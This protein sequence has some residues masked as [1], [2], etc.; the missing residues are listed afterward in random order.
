MPF[1]ASIDSRKI[2]G[3]S[4]VSTDSTI[5]VTAASGKLSFTLTS[6]G[7]ATEIR[8]LPDTGFAGFN[9]PLGVTL[10]L[11]ASL[12]NGKAMFGDGVAVAKAKLGGENLSA[13][14]LYTDKILLAD[15]AAYTLQASQAAIAQIG[16]S[17]VA[18]DLRSTNVNSKTTVVAATAA[19]VSLIQLDKN[20]TLVLGAGQSY[21]LTADQAMVGKVGAGAVGD[22]LTSGALLIKAAKDADLS[23]LK[24]KPNDVLELGAGEDYVLN[25]A[26]TAV[27]KVGASGALGMF[28]GAGAVTVKANAATGEDLSLIKATGIDVYELAAG[29]AYTLTADQL[30]VARV[31][32]TG[33]TG[34]TKGAGVVTV[35]V[36]TVN[37]ITKLVTKATDVLL[38]NT[39]ADYRLTSEQVKIAKVGALTNKSGELGN[40]GQ[41]TV[42]AG[43]NNPVNALFRGEDLSGLIAR[44]VDFYELSAGSDYG[45]TTA[46]AKV[47]KVGTGALGN[48][49]AAGHVTLIAE[50]TGENLSLSPIAGVDEY[51][52]TALQTYTMTAEQALKARVLP[53]ANNVLGNF[54]DLANTKTTVLAGSVSDLTPI[55]IDA[56]DV[57]WLTANQDY[58]LSALQASVSRVDDG[59]AGPSSNPPGSLAKAGRVVIKANPKGE[60]LATLL[61]KVTGYDVIELTAGAKYSLTSAQAE[62][63]MVIAPPGNTGANN[64]S[65]VSGILGAA[66]N[67]PNV[68]FAVTTTS[69][70]TVTAGI[71]GSVY[72]Q[73]AYRG[74]VPEVYKATFVEQLN[75]NFNSWTGWENGRDITPFVTLIG[76]NQSSVVTVATGAGLSGAAIQIQVAGM[77]TPWSG[78]SLGLNSATDP[79]RGNLSSAGS[80]LLVAND[81]GEDLSG[82]TVQGIKGIQLTVGKDYTLTATQALM[83]S[84]SAAGNSVSSIVG[85]GPVGD[86]TYTPTPLAV[87]AKTGVMTIWANENNVDLTKLKTDA[88]DVLVLTAGHNYKLNVAQ[89]LTA[90]MGPGGTVGQLGGSGNITVVV[91]ASSTD[92]FKLNLDQGDLI[93]L[94]GGLN[95][96]LATHQLPL[97][98]MGGNNSLTKA[99][100]VTVVAS[101][102][103]EDLTGF[104]TPGIDAYVLNPAVNYSLR[105]DQAK[106]SRVG[107]SPVLGD[108]SSMTGEVNLRVPAAVSLPLDLTTI[109]LKDSDS[110]QLMSG[111]R[112]IL[113]AKQAAMA[114][115]VT[116]ADVGP[117]GDLSGAAQ[118]TVRP[119]AGNDLTSLLAG[120]QGIDRIDLDPEASYTLNDAQARMAGFG[121]SGML[122]ELASKSANSKLTLVAGDSVYWVDIQIDANDKIILQPNRAYTLTAEQAVVSQMGSQGIAGILANPLDDLSIITVLAPNSADLSKLVLDGNDYL[123]LGSGQRYTLTSALAKQSYLPSWSNVVMGDLSA[124]GAVRILAAPTGEDLSSLLIDAND[125]LVLT[126]GANY[127][128]TAAQAAIGVM[129][130]TG[131]KGK[132]AGTGVLT[133]K[134]GATSDLTSLGL[135]TQGLPTAVDVIQLD[136]NQNYSLTP[137]QA[138]VARVGSMGALGQLQEAGVL[139]IIASASGEDLSLLKW[140]GLD[141]NDR[142]VLTKAKNYTLTKDQLALAVVGAGTTG[143][144]TSAGVITLKSGSGLNE[145]LSTVSSVLGV[146]SVVLRNGVNT[147]LTDE[148]AMVAKLGTG[149]VRDLRGPVTP[150][151]VNEIMTLKSNDRDADLAPITTDNND[152]IWLSRNFNYSLNSAQVSRVT[153][154]GQTMASFAA[155]T[156]QITLK[157]SSIGEDLSG[158]NAAMVDV[159]Q[160]TAG[161]SYTLTPEQAQIATLGSGLAVQNT[162]VSYSG[163]ASLSGLPS[164]TH[165]YTTQI[166]LDTT[167][168]I[169]GGT[170]TMQVVLGNGTSAAS[171]DLYKNEIT[172][173]GAENRP[174]N[175]LKNAYYVAPGTTT[176]LS[177]TFPSS[178]TDTYVFGVEGNW[179]SPTSATNT[180]TYSINITGDAYAADFRNAG[181]ITIKA[182]PDGDNQLKTKLSFM[183]GLGVIALADAKDYTLSAGQALIARMGSATTPAVLTSTG[184]IT[185]DDADSALGSSVNLTRLV[186]DNADVLMLGRG[187]YDL[188]SSQVRKA[189]STIATAGTV[190]LWASST[191]ED[192]SNISA[193]T[194]DNVYLTA[195]RDYTLSLDQV[196][197]S[198]V[199]VFG[200][201][202][203]LTKAGKVTLKLSDGQSTAALTSNQAIKGVDVIQLIA[204]D[205]GNDGIRFTLSSG[206]S[207]QLQMSID[208]TAAPMSFFKNTSSNSTGGGNTGSDGVVNA[209]GEWSFVN[210]TDVLTYYSLMSAQSVTLIGVASVTADGSAGLKI[211]F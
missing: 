176:N 40:A 143:D 137:A 61:S 50:K 102:A 128:L 115:V 12:A 72:V 8:E 206:S 136:V 154:D 113:T 199:G 98:R 29:K 209:P 24:I 175:S 83:A 178:S 131:A 105:V 207:K 17:G 198:K 150:G 39:N 106:I 97:V 146:D 37:D 13:Y 75:P 14:V 104:D 57:F 118:I 11:D 2:I 20:D 81:A 197:K 45:L 15:G 6:S 107:A 117:R 142:I 140:P 112:Y 52:L 109:V 79:V 99:G 91:D 125:T 114:S 87:G 190:N 135:D 162:T 70:G 193:A 73:Y 183:K 164:G 123:Q 4:G 127:T 120:V 166:R 10:T 177:Y 181:L 155:V 64:P 82:L 126:L 148:Q 149:N 30:A 27:A 65:N 141:S 58:T 74:D 156:G 36:G 23:G 94:T 158:I 187:N 152:L 77:I 22:Y 32:S 96:T 110:L 63:A 119:A 171:Y 28:G 89:A 3:F 19:D 59:L 54:G 34:D 167:K 35:K 211:G 205:I 194:L 188:T 189:A 100:A 180:F 71:K 185:V 201:A 76:N 210:S 62:L 121:K 151:A 92:L 90:K 88:N 182:N 184:V 26:Q 179:F 69:T 200:A 191:G 21:T 38:L 147:T 42:V 31:G 165:N 78:I 170:M 129:G 56:N 67:M 47:A 84:I 132:L 103:G 85:T 153:F 130:T 172:T 111:S 93:E 144:L 196:A 7:G 160:L 163:N 66:D 55:G 186:L 86:L 68:Q 203:D 174:I 18:G 157:A 101:S 116:G 25:S 133:V 134:A 138:S 41:I 173:G 122:G 169:N 9:V 161:R 195:S 16:A 44:G 124:A 139:T 204:R 53:N 95:Y 202:G 1:S 33:V 48:L 46:Q 145:D 5:A 192:L 208:E 168:F 60:E 43:L 159:I 80:I 108:L 51:R 49:S